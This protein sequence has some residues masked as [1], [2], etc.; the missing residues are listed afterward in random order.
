M[1]ESPHRGLGRALHSK[2]EKIKIL[3][4]TEEDGEGWRQGSRKILLV[5]SV[6]GFHRTDGQGL[7]ITCN[8]Q[9]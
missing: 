5:V 9:S 8:R 6:L 2:L 3:P 7:F 1:M 4:E